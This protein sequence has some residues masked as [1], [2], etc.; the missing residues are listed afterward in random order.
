MHSLTI[1]RSSHDFKKQ[2]HLII[3]INSHDKMQLFLADRNMSCASTLHPM[4]NEQLIGVLKIFRNN[5]L[6]IGKHSAK[7]TQ[8]FEYSQGS[9]IGLNLLRQ[10]L[11]YVQLQVMLEHTAGISFQQTAVI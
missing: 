6:H 11:M 1:D 8:L 4:F 10:F 2:L 9:K 3:T 5:V 7:L